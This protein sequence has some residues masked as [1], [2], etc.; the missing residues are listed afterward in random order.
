[1]ASKNDIEAGK[2]YVTL[3]VKNSAFVKSLRNSEATFKAA[4]SNM[5]AVGA[6]IMA[7]GVG[8]AAPLAAAVASF[9]NTGDELDKMSKRTGASVEALSELGFAAQ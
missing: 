3:Y 8:I 5:Q 6:S 2:A 7:A 1:M 4:G 9:V